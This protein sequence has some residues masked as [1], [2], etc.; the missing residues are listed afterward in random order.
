LTDGGFDTLIPV[1][2]TTLVLLLAFQSIRV[3]SKP[4]NPSINNSDVIMA[5]GVKD[6]FADGITILGKL[7]FPAGI[8]PSIVEIELEDQNGV[9]VNSTKSEPHNQFR[10][11]RVPIVDVANSSFET[12]YLII[13]TEGF[14]IVR[15]QLSLNT[16]NFSG[17]QVTIQLH[18]IPGLTQRNSEAVVSIAGLQ[19]EPP[20]GALRAFDKAMEEQGKGDTRKA[21]LDFE[22]AVNLAP[23]FYEANLELGLQYE[24]EGEHDR[25][26]RLLTHAL[27]I[28]PASMRARAALGKRAYETDDFQKAAEMLGEAVRLGN[29]SADVYFMLGASCFRIDDLDMAEA[30]LQR[31]LAISPSIGQAHL[32]LYNVYLKR[33]QMDKGLVELDAYLQKFP[34]APD[35]ERIQALAD[36]LRKALQP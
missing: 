36:K 12:Y 20:K 21:A 3:N 26:V 19:E 17:A 16:N 5:P 10:F 32:A 8:A 9:I 4:P 22:K 30:S 28:N 14:D 29:T 1:M 15:Q 25:A 27:E 18:R 2:L 13:N 23:N 31:A 7:V 24:Q 6:H 33:R 11:T 35:H 34:D